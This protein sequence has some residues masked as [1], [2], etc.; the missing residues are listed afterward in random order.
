MAPYKKN[1]E[2]K[3][4]VVRLGECVVTGSQ[5]MVHNAQKFTHPLRGGALIKSLAI[6]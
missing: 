3:A 6:I 2:W 5:G 1:N 4:E